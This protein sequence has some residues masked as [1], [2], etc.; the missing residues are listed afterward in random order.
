MNGSQ[1]KRRVNQVSMM[2]KLGRMTRFDML[3]NHIGDAGIEIY[4]NLTFDE[5]DDKN[6]FAIVVAKCDAYFTKRD[7]QLMLREKCWFHLRREPGQSI[8]SWVNT[9]KENAAEC[10]FP[11]TSLCR[12]GCSG[13]DMLMH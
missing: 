8:D 7:P 3:L 12:T 9:V 4:A 11:C 2:L 1:I 6:D 5:I 10:K 13:S